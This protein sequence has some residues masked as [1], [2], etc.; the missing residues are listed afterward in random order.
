MCTPFQWLDESQV[1][2]SGETQRPLGRWQ[3]LR[4]SND[5]H[6]LSTYIWGQDFAQLRSAVLGT[7][8]ETGSFFGLLFFL[9]MPMEPLSETAT[10]L[11]ST[12]FWFGCLEWDLHHLV[13][14]QRCTGLFS[15]YLLAISCIIFSGDKHN[16]YGFHELNSQRITL[17]SGLG[18]FWSTHHIH[19][20]EYLDKTLL[21]RCPLKKEW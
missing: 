10:F 11:F 3:R 19:Q 18:A 13:S 2:L 16:Q 7:M 8:V 5:L 15:L 6:R 14:R 1:S 21:G 9:L 4:K 20:S 17:S 12:G